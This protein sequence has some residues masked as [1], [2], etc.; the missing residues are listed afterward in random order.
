MHIQY[1]YFKTV[2]HLQSVCYNSI[3]SLHIKINYY[4]RSF[5]KNVGILIYQKRKKEIKS[6]ILLWVVIVVTIEKSLTFY[7]GDI[8]RNVL[9]KSKFS[10]IIIEWK[11]WKNSFINLI[12]LSKYIYEK[13]SP[14]F[15]QKYFLCGR[16]SRTKTSIWNILFLS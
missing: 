3:F 9:F 5:F 4:T 1:S 15:E 16:K 8:D 12:R 6:L 10:I 14:K 2:W 13:S 7:S 11:L